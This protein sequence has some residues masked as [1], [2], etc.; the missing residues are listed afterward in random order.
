[1]LFSSRKKEE[2]RVVGKRRKLQETVG[3]CIKITSKTKELTKK[4]GAEP[5]ISLSLNLEPLQLEGRQV[6]ENE[7]AISSHS[8]DRSCGGFVSGVVAQLRNTTIS[9][10]GLDSLKH[11]LHLS[12]ALSFLSNTCIGIIRVKI[13]TNTGV[14]KKPQ[15][16]IFEYWVF[17]QKSYLNV[18]CFEEI[19][20]CIPKI[21]YLHTS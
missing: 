13:H 21:R 6:P 19:H 12:H 3:N 15:K 14:N 5:E 10:I 2:N 20:I 16:L 8:G 4:S 7:L 18:G 17:S 11:L 1:M 9:T